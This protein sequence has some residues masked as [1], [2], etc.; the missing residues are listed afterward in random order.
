MIPDVTTIDA[1]AADWLA[2]VI[3]VV[4]QSTLL[5]GV[6]AVVAWL[7]RRS[8]PAVRYWL[9]Q[10]V[11]IKI[12]LAP[13]WTLAVPIAWLP[14]ASEMRQTIAVRAPTR[15]PPTY[16]TRRLRQSI[17]KS[18]SRATTRRRTYTDVRPLWSIAHDQ[19]RRPRSPGRRG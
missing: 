16:E 12:L 10:I 11:A 8:S 7:L 9:W 18:P 19:L 2:L 6:V 5:A 1:L 13:V 14:E 3:A 4:W 15:R 17:L